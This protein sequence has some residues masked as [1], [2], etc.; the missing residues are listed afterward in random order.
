MTKIA[1][2][3]RDEWWESLKSEVNL[4]AKNEPAFAVFYLLNILAHEGLGEAL[5]YILAGKLAESDPALKLTRDDLF[6]M[7]K[8]CYAANPE[9]VKMAKQDLLAVVDRDPAVTNARQPLLFFKGF[10]ALQAHRIAHVFWKEKRRDLAM[11]MQSQSS[12]RFQVDIH[13][14]AVLGHGIMIDHAT[15]VVI[16]ETATVGNDV[17]MLHGVTLGGT[18]K[19]GEDRH[20]KIG[21]G[22]LL[23]ANA[24]VLGNFKVGK[25]S[26]VAA[27][28]VVLMEVPPNVTVAGIPAR[29][30]GKAGCAKPGTV[31]DQI[32]GAIP[33]M[34]VEKSQSFFGKKRK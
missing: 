26:R 18:G 4:C 9:L 11:F 2:T 33:E 32:F 13:P 5:A 12:S 29:I 34:L 17:S 27:G 25:C 16:G 21:D 30:V 28:S 19:E 31:M 15:G 8:N 23:G 22:V 1:K 24:T 10:H 3:K 6:A 14:A 20:P 7:F